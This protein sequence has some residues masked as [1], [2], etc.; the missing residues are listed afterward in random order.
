VD[1]FPYCVHLA[2][3]VFTLM[4]LCKGQAWREAG[5]GVQ[6]PP[7]VAAATTTSSTLGNC[8]FHQQQPLRG[9]RTIRKDITAHLLPQGDALGPVVEGK[10]CGETAVANKHCWLEQACWTE[11]VTS[12][13]ARQ[14]SAYQAIVLQQHA[15]HS[16][17]GMDG[18][19]TAVATARGG[20][21]RGGVL[22]VVL[23]CLLV[24]VVVL[25]RQLLCWHGDQEVQS[26]LQESSRLC[27]QA[28]QPHSTAASCCMQLPAAARCS[29]CQHSCRAISS[30]QLMASHPARSYSKVYSIP[31]ST[32]PSSCSSAPAPQCPAA[33]QLDMQAHPGGTS[34]AVL[35]PG[36]SLLSQLAI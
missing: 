34:A 15:A 11:H 3:Y 23:Y 29:P 22:L 17:W 16:R 33:P 21:M 9:S 26:V 4:V 20:C 27:H 24:L 13:T 36:I 5:W 31:C 2:R 25:G 14:H 6:Q 10:E 30:R 28:L 12:S 7:V 1:A 18:G 8:R 19:A 32:A 35:F